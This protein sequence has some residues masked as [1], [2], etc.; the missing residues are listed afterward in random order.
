MFWWLL[1]AW[2]AG[3]IELFD[4]KSLKGWYRTREAQAPLPSW[5]AKNGVLQTAPGQGKEV[6]LLSEQEFE[7]FD[8]GFEWRAA[9]GAN[10]GIKY[11]IQTYG[12]SQRRI[13]PV[14]LEYQ[15]TDD[16]RN[17]DALST[18]RHT[19]GAIYDYVA[20]RKSRAAVA[21]IWHQGR[22][23]VRGL[24]VEHWLDGERVVSVDLDS[25][26]AEASFQES[27]RESRHM[28]RRQEK[29]VSPI[30]LQIHDGRVEFRNL[31][32]EPLK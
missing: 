21:E 30:A 11:R 5:E 25:A 29:R 6:Y 23:V 9:A 4:G 10:S 12:D 31:R 32:V 1:L 19:A 2:G 16:E 14:G 27:K 3:P 13:E 24:H 7:D 18:P 28:L 8:F 20:P 22:I 15:I 26:E 17:P